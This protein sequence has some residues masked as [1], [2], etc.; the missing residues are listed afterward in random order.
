MSFRGVLESSVTLSGKHDYNFVVILLKLT[1]IDWPKGFAPFCTHWKLRTVGRLKLKE[2][3]GKSASQRQLQRKKF[4][5]EEW[6]DNQIPDK[7]T[8]TIDKTYTTK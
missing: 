8:N 3:S 2:T 7:P 5:F 6:I 1:L 4:K